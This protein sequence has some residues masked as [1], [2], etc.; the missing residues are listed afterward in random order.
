MLNTIQARRLERSHMSDILQ[1]IDEEVRRKKLEEFWKKYRVAVLS[2]GAAIV[3]TVGGYQGWNYYQTSL[4]NSS[5]DAFVAAA[6]IF[7]KGEGFE[8]QAADAFAK[9]AADGSTGY[10]AVARMQEASARAMGGERDRAITLY[11]EVANSGEGGPLI[12][13]FARLRAALL[14]AETASFADLKKR[15]EPIEQSSPWSPLAQEILGYAAWRTGDMAE[16][17][18]RF[19]LLAN[20]NNAPAGVRQRAG[21]MRNLVVAGVRPADIEKAK[22]APSLLPATQPES[23]LPLP[24]TLATPEITEGP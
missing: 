8:K 16:A 4:R 7:A 22:P 24:P 10:R 3:A 23:L 2:A 1:E 19:D 17:Q 6:K 5:S 15:L 18:K 9:V 12:A 11:D 14:H 13:Q 21:E 20:D